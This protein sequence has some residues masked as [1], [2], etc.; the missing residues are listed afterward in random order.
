MARGNSRSEARG[1][2]LPN[3][4]ER[5]RARQQVERA[6]Q[7]LNKEQILPIVTVLA[8]STATLRE[9]EELADVRGS[10]TDLSVGT[11]WAIF[12]A[13]EFDE[14][15]CNSNFDYDFRAYRTVQRNLGLLVG[16][17]HWR[18]AMELAVELMRWG[19]E[20]I[21]ASDEGL[22]AEEIGDCVRVVT[23][24][25]VH[26]ELP[27]MSILSWC[28]AMAAADATGC[29]EDQEFSELKQWANS[30]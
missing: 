8:R 11:R 10:L 21:C 7:S 3:L 6:L 15:D 19:S 17:G 27:S 2:L 4:S 12:D 28:G 26:S 14:R 23:R 25:L 22:M 5:E 30:R 13:T 29:L 18:E 16:A 1:H 20:Q 24:G 9:L